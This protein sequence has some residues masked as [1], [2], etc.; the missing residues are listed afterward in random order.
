MTLSGDAGGNVPFQKT[1]YVCIFLYA[2]LNNTVDAISLF[3]LASIFH[4]TNLAVDVRL[5]RGIFCL[6]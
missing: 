4:C 2:L 1:L 3:F 6:K 5:Q